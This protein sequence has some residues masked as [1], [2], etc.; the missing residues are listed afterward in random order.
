M[1]GGHPTTYTEEVAQKIID[2]MEGSSDPLSTML[3]SRDDLPCPSTVYKWRSENE[4]F[5][6]RLQAAQLKNCANA[7]M[8]DDS[9][10]DKRLNYY[11]DKEGNK[12]ID[13]P[14]VQLLAM[15]QGGKRWLL[16]KLM[17]QVYGDKPEDTNAG[18]NLI[19]EYHK[20]NDDAKK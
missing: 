8:D 2:A 14:S 7:I 11:I 9:Y 16:Q 1:P 19:S 18:Q 15:K 4:D 20:D 5:S 6:D 12:R 13:A 17:P 3:K 10:L